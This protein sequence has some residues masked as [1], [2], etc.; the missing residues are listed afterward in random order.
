LFA[1]RVGT[2]FSEK[3]L[4]GIDANLQKLRRD[5]CHETLP[6]GGTRAGSISTRNF[7]SMQ[8]KE[9]EDFCVLD[10]TVGPGD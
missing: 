2:A 6:L 7:I 5:T 8:I 3:P 10:D 4:A 9:R 1:G